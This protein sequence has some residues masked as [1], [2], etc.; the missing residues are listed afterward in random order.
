MMRHTADTRAPRVVVVG[1]GLAAWMSAAYLRRVLR[2]IGSPVT[3]VAAAAAPEP[4]AL[5]TRPA[6]TRFLRGFAVD[7]A[8]FMRRCGATYALANRY[9]GWFEEGAGHWHPYGECGPRIDGLDLFHPWLKHR[10]DGEEAGAYGDY[11]PQTHMAAAGRGPAPEEGGS[12]V[13]EAGSYGYHL[14]RAGLVPF[15][16]EIAISEGVR[17]ITGRVVAAETS[18]LGDVESLTLEGGAS[19]AGD[20]FVDGTGAAAFLIGGTLGEPWIEDAAAGVCD[21]LASLALP[22]DPARPPFTTYA[23]APEG[24]TSRLPLAGRTE[25]SLAYRSE[26]TGPE[27]AET[28]LRDLSGAAPGAAIR[29]RVLR[30]GRRRAPWLRNVV[31]IGASARDPGPLGGF[32]A[33]L[34]VCALEA[35]VEHL[36]RGEG[37]AVLRQ[38]Y[39][40]RMN[41]L[42]DEAF[43]AVA[44]HYALGR[45]TEPFWAAARAAPLPDALADRLDLYEI[46]GRVSVPEARLFGE[47]DHYRLLAGADLL[48]RRTFAPVDLAGPRGLGTFL[49]GI[50]AR[51]VQIAETM[52]PHALLM[53][54]LHG[55]A[56]APRAE[57]R[58][59]P[60]ARAAAG[61]EA[62]RRSEDGARLADLVA[63][64]GQP[65]GYE[66]SVKASAGVLQTDRFLMSLHRTSL[67]PESGPVLDALAA[68]LGL[69]EAARAEAAALMAEA[70]LLHLGYEDGPAGPLYKLYVEWSARTDAAFADE[71]APGGEPLLVHRAYK[72]DPRRP[73][74]P[75][76]TLYHWPRVRTPEAIAARLSRLGAGE[77]GWGEAGPRVLAPARALLDLA[78]ARGRGLPHYLEA[79]E[80]PGPRLSYDLNLY[81]CGLPVAAAE[82]LLAG[83]FADLGVPPPEAAS[84]LA[85]RREESLGHVAG[86]VGRD[87]RPFL[88]LYS[89]VA[90]G[91]GT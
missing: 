41:D 66:R 4:G 3:L 7:E 10:L 24:W 27:A 85:E 13:T 59:A 57:V 22:P 79:R 68:K 82:P 64:L 50:R 56:E 31:A 21:R 52:A 43:G 32:E 81:A 75:V 28:A 45:R 12:A 78:R 53:E 83:A 49:A 40:R 65:F 2:R 11:A 29:H 1:G 69:A 30:T 39:A 58:V 84:V 54:R 26:A 20:I 33:D 37:V 55:P 86:G 46:G 36:P 15:F 17:A 48:P 5:A 9:D 35:F 77:A 19:V 70:D 76:V 74:P 87:G 44:L 6:F 71:G 61:P 42:A 72:W 90:A 67:G 89:G 47:S 14:D 91:S 34:I 73:G 88:T 51:A 62:L 25:A 38:A 63:G 23:G 60:A 18:P 80:A 16:R 8:I